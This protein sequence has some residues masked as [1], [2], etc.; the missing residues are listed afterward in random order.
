MAKKITFTFTDGNRY[1]LEFNREAVQAMES[2][3]FNLTKLA[4]APST[5][6]PRL[7]AGALRMH[8]SKLK[9]AMIDKMLEYMGDKEKLLPKLIE[10]YNETVDTVMDDPEDES[11]K[12][13]WEA[14]WD[15]EEDS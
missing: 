15:E 14:N 1:T 4:D 3:G 11:K 10:M 13:T 7:F 9:P 5:N 2:R 12:V 6:I 8:H